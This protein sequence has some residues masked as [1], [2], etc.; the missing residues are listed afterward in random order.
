MASGLVRPVCACCGAK[1][2]QLAIVMDPWVDSCYG[3]CQACMAPLWKNYH[4]QMV[5]SLTASGPGE[6]PE[7]Y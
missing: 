7:G 6:L 1:T 3:V 4:Q 2:D 5:Q